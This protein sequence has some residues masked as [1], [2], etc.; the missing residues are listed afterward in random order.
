[1]MRTIRLKLRTTP[2]VMA[3]L[4]KTMEDF[5]RAVRMHIEW[6][7]MNKNA[8]KCRMHEA[9]YRAVGAEMPLLRA[10]LVQTA[11][12]IACETLRSTHFEVRPKRGIHSGIRYNDNCMSVFLQGGYATLSTNNGRV[13]VE[14]CLP[15]YHAILSDWRV[16]SS[17]LSYR[18]R[19]NELYLGVVVENDA[20]QIAS[21]GEAI[22]VDRGLKNIA[23]T[24][25][26]Q[27][28]S[29]RKTKG[30]RGRYA[31]LRKRLQRKGTRSAKRL[32]KKVAGQERRFNIC[33]NH[34]IAK[35]IVNTPCSV[36]V[37]EDLTEIRRDMNGR[38]KMGDWV[39]VWP[40]YQLGE[41]IK[42][43]A[44]AAGKRVLEVN[45]ADTSRKCSRCGCIDKRNRVGNQF[46]CLKCGFT[47]NPDLN[48]ARNIA[49]RGR[50]S[51][52]RLPV[53][54]P[55]ASRDEERTACEAVGSFGAQM[56]VP[57][58]KLQVCKEYHRS[59]GDAVDT[60]CFVGI[61]HVGREIGTVDTRN[62]DFTQRSCSK[63]DTSTLDVSP[64]HLLRRLSPGESAKGDLRDIALEHTIASSEVCRHDW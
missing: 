3:M 27:F 54:Q 18:K 17:T 2:E 40:F 5:N 28:F 30:I 11:R 53:D 22:G 48:A 49:E 16:K 47:L 57:H 24:S 23:V 37:L 52:S 10:G 31:F 19:K 41:F 39:A 8:N 29:S 7:W 51:L 55:N 20:P 32:L 25:D 36:I 26:N 1:M 13:K 38:G 4:L 21:S 44:E 60:G 33:Q 42:Y 64:E 14:F 43:K 63:R 15:E 34:I 50:S 62:L 12:D 46:H 45:P 56:Q 6:G 59:V 35:K 58:E 9:V 61:V